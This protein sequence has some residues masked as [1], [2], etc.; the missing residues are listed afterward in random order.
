MHRRVY[1]RILC[2]T[3]LFHSM[4]GIFLV[5]G[6]AGCGSGDDA[7][8]GDTAGGSKNLSWTA[9]SDPSVLGYKVYWG[10]SSNTYE[11]QVDVGANT[12]YIITG[13]RRGTTHFFAVSAYSGDG[14][15]LPSAEVSSLVE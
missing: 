6:T 7:P 13:L 11:S 15:G 1:S 3:I 5:T 12:S 10:T 2:R 8:S 14:E 4:L 9:V